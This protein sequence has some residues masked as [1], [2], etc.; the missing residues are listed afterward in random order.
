MA[1]AQ[2]TSA[3]S[4]QLTSTSIAPSK[5]V[6]Y[7]QDQ[8]HVSKPAQAMNTAV[9]P[10]QQKQQGPAPLPQGDPVP[11]PPAPLCPE[12][13]PK[14]DVRHLHCIRLAKGGTSFGNPPRVVVFHLLWGPEIF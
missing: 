4:Q 7:T 11:M 13:L 1:L 10:A 5:S 12:T 3:K 9:P 14:D 8:S 2:Q 6:D